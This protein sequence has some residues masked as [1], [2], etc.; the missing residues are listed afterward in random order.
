MGSVLGGSGCAREADCKSAPRGASPCGRSEAWKAPAPGTGRTGWARDI[1]ETLRQKVQSVVPLRANLIKK[2]MVWN[3][4][5]R[6]TRGSR[7]R[8]LMGL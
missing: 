7:C 1:A 8:F 6:D 2:G 4:S 5:Y 3:P